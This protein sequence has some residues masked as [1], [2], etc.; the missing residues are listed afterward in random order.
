M[1][2]I[3]K[4]QFQKFCTSF[5]LKT[6]DTSP[7][8]TK[9]S[10]A[11]NFEKFV[12]YLV[13]TS[14][15]P[16][17]FTGNTGLLD[18]ICVGGSNDTGIDGI[19]IKINDT[20]I[21]SKD[22][23]NKLVD[24]NKKISVE[25]YFIQTKTSPGF[26]MGDFVKFSLGIRNFFSEGYLPENVHIKELR[27]IMEYIYSDTKIVAK[28]ENAPKLFIYYVTTGADI[29][30]DLNYQGA[31]KSLENDLK[32]STMYFD[33]IIIDNL[34]GKKLIKYYREIENKFEVLLNI[35]DI[36]PLIVNLQ[37]KEDIKKAY[38]FTCDAKE[39]LKILT[40]DDGQLRRSLFYTNVRDYL[41]NKGNVNSEIEETITNN[42]EL[43][44]LCNNGVTLV[45]TEFE[46]VR[47]KLV[48]IE[49]PQIV[50]GCQ[51]SN[52][53][54]N[55]RDHQNISKVQLLVRV[56][57]TE[58]L[59]ISNRIVRGTNKQN[60]VLDEAF[61]VTRPYH[62]DVL[63]P[64]FISVQN[65]SKLYYE[66]RSNQFS[67]DENVKITQMVNLSVLTQS[68][69]SMMLN[70]PHDGHLRTANLLET[71]GGDSLN[72]KIFLDSHDP[73]IYH[74][75]ALTWN[76]LDKCLR[77][78]ILNNKYKPYKAH[79]AFIISNLINDKPNNYNASK[80]TK[81][82]C[83]KLNESINESNLN[84]TLK[85]SIEIFNKVQKKWQEQGKSFYGMK[86]NKE[87]TDLLLKE[88]NPQKVFD[89]KIAE[90]K[91][92]Q[93]LVGRIVTIIKKN[94]IWFG[95]IDQGSNYDNIYFDNRGYSND[96]NDLQINLKVMYEVGYNQQGEMAKN[97]ILI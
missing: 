92:N 3:L 14:D 76:T 39:F 88:I 13:F 25:Y 36:F 29:N 95:F 35:K 59:D 37:E 22:I 4:H 15:S 26:D 47:D 53:I 6:K 34:C 57:S 43:F 81:K 64:F 32:N 67:N 30:N 17:M 27:D 40:K 65:E 49:S 18:Y 70:R 20:I 19:A 71:L 51:T 94:G 50:N 60:Q 68:F 44:L 58:N 1:D 61:E 11:K 90:E 8:E 97:V 79:F 86:D 91:I 12:N 89:E 24:T 54:Y 52:S 28:L 33:S 63:E 23:I 2:P 7:E 45:C 5:E 16:G 62:Q 83:V 93:Q 38:S 74:C 80:S 41:G 87:F 77:E 84:I 21:D 96:V 56:I 9:K 31:K 48:K 46:Q 85:K 66:R 78:E 10:E 73:A 42:P 69:V 72:R 55:L 82:Y 75:C